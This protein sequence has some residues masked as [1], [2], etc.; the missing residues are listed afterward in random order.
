MSFR[1]GEFDQEM[2]E[3]ALVEGCEAAQLQLMNL[4]SQTARVHCFN[5]GMFFLISYS[6]ICPVIK[7]VRYVLHLKLSF[8]QW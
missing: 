5:V 7:Y 1:F 2:I 4:W 8:L 6:L 3:Q